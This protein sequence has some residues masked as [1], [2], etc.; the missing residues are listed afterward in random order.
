MPL[1]RIFDERD[2]NELMAQNAGGLAGA[3]NAALILSGVC[4]GLTPLEQS[5]VTT[6]SIVAPNG[7]LYRIWVLPSHESYNGKPREL[8]TEDHLVPYF[9]KYIDFR[10][11][12]NWK[13]GGHSHQSLL[14]DKP[15]FLNDHGESY[16]IRTTERGHKSAKAMHDQLRK[17][18]KNCN[19]HGATPASYRASFIKIM[20]EAG[21]R[22]SELKELT[23]IRDN[24]TLEGLVR[25]HE[26]E[27]ELIM[28]KIFSRVKMPG[29]LR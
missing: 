6:E 24:R 3:R 1:E 12:E 28:G 29:S 27:L 20:Y 7:Q 9:Q 11:K 26:R 5:L 18:I 15:F 14:P 16:R 21:V 2:I 19:M 4:W 23:G 25:P 13:V 22:W 17:M 10:L 8:F